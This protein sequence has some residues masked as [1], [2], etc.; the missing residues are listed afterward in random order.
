MKRLVF[1]LIILITV[2]NGI[3]QVPQ[4]FNYQA[5]LRDSDGEPS[6]SMNISLEVS[7]TTAEGI[8]VYTET[9]DIQTDETGMVN[10]AIGQGTTS[11]DLSL[12]DWTNGPYFLALIVNGEPMGSSPLLSVPYA[13]YAASGNEGPP[14]PQGDAGPQGEPG[15]TGPEGPKGDQGDPGQQGPQGEQGETGPSGPKGDPG[16]TRWDSISGGIAYLDGLIGVGT[17]EPTEHLDVAGNTRVRGNLL[18]DGQVV[19]DS[20]NMENLLNELKLLRQMAG[21]GTVTDIDGHVYRTVKIGE[22]TWMAENLRTSRLNDGTPLRYSP[23]PLDELFPNWNGHYCW[24]NNDSATYEA[25][26]GKLYAVMNDL[27]CPSGWHIPSSGEWDILEAHLGNNAGGKMKTTGTT[28]W[29]PPNTGATNESGFSG[30]PGG[31]VTHLDDISTDQHFFTGAGVE[32]VWMVTDFSLYPRILK[33]SSGE[34]YTEIRDHM[35]AS[36][37][38]CIKD[39]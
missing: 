24:Y 20:V 35:A 13:L 18:V 4:S 34:L 14:G 39:E 29:D 32:C 15:E 1:G 37:I 19:V 31:E 16:D 3:S 33:Y 9:H 28:Y 7:I 6:I 12:V 26:Y 38:R 10:V 36:S 17:E 25:L 21:V 30:L 23:V 27:L 2:I 5:I 11:E 8:P 22:Q